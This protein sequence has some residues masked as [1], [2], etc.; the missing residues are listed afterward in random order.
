ME[1]RAS[2]VP[3]QRPAVDS[4]PS[5]LTHVEV[6]STKRMHYTLAILGVITAILVAILLA[7]LVPSH[8]SGQVHTVT[9]VVA[10]LRHD[11]Q[12][13]TGRTLVVSGRVVAYLCP[14]R[15]PPFP[16]LLMDSRV[17]YSPRTVCPS[18][19]SISLTWTRVDPL[20]AFALRAPVLGSFVPLR[21]GGVG[22]Y[23]V[24]I[25]PNAAVCNGVPETYQ[26]ILLDGLR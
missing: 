3:C 23:R 12:R 6:T 5:H 15:C 19:S 20:V 18:P 22:T 17:P 7:S 10:G 24:R 21:R 13:W 25:I 2:R 26:A 9:E 14:G 4:P 1:T 16:H 8:Y 11:P